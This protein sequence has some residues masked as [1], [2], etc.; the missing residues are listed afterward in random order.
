MPLEVVKYMAGPYL[1]FAFPTTTIIGAVLFLVR[2]GRSVNVAFESIMGVTE[3][4][5]FIIRI[6][7]PE[8]HQNNDIL[9]P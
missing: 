4:E 1:L 6:I 9:H 7:I 3:V 8:A 2:G 5:K